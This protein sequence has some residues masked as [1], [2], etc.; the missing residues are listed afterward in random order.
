MSN[1]LQNYVDMIANGFKDLA[2]CDDPVTDE[3]GEYRT[4]DG[5][6]TTICERVMDAL[7]VRYT[8]NSRG[9]FLGGAIAVTIG[10]PNVW[11]DT[12][13]REVVGYWGGKKATAPLHFEAVDQLYDVLSEMHACL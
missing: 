9:E 8:V 5:D 10:G 13:D 2:L 12:E 4:E 7:D 3:Y 6:P 11:V 1:D